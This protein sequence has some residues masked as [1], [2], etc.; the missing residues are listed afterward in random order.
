MSKTTNL[1]FLSLFTIALTS[2]WSCKPD[3]E[4]IIPEEE[5]EEL[6]KVNLTTQ[7]AVDS[8]GA[9]GLKSFAGIIVI[10]TED[11][12]KMNYSITN[13]NAFSS[14]AK[15]SSLYVERNEN[16]ISLEGLGSIDSIGSYY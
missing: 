9:L 10:G 14:I 1:L 12:S 11:S 5:V 13:L 7:E 16:L 8:F 3:E 4:P 15:I 6:P 2:I